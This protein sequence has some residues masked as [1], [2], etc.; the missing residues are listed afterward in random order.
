MNSASAIDIGRPAIRRDT[1]WHSWRGELKGS[2][3]RWA[4]ACIVPS[5]VVFLASL[6]FSQF[7]P[8]PTLEP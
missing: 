2:E 5:I 8:N 7:G 6:N 4:L 3:S 1:R